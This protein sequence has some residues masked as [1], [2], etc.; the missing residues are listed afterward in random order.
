MIPVERSKLSHKDHLVVNSIELVK[1]DMIHHAGI[2]P[3][4]MHT[5]VDY[6]QTNL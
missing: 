1:Y 3:N 2:N 5:Y 4:I 6:N